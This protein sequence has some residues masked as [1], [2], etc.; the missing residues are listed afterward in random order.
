[1]VNAHNQ[2]L[3]LF[4]KDLLLLLH[5]EHLPLNS[6]CR[7]TQQNW[8]RSTE[9]VKADVVTKSRRFYKSPLEALK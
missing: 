7:K 2:I 8:K 9:I 1:M 5:K 6:V 3:A 4:W